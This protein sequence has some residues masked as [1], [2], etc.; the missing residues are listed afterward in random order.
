[1][2]KIRIV[3]TLCFTVWTAIGATELFWQFGRHTM[4]VFRIHYLVRSKCWQKKLCKNSNRQQFS[5]FVSTQG[6]YTIYINSSDKS[7]F[8]RFLLLVDFSKGI[9]FKYLVDDRLAALLEILKLKNVKIND[10]LKMRWYCLPQSTALSLQI[11]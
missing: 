4:Y 1:M 8:V 9:H 5:F 7:R 6:Q 3:W 2:S 11:T 10:P